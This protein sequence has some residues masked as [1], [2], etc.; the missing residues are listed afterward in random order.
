MG[1]PA[2]YDH[3]ERGNKVQMHL[4]NSPKASYDCSFHSFLS[5]KLFKESP[6]EHVAKL[7][8]LR[9]PVCSRIL[10]ISLLGGFLPI[11]K[12]VSG[13]VFK[14][15]WALS[16]QYRSSLLGLWASSAGLKDSQKYFIKL[17]I[18]QNLMGG[19][20]LKIFFLS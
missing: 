2:V 13:A 18:P 11:I 19:K 1:C 9:K 10:H 12:G 17:A 8:S 15:L 14:N 20:S 5:D 6:E 7:S 4:T 16:L 3:V